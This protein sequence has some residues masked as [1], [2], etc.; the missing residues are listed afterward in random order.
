MNLHQQLLIFRTCLAVLVILRK[1]VQD[2]HNI[3]EKYS[4]NLKPI[5]ALINDEV[6]RLYQENEQTKV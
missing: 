5:I 4:Q 3:S 6:N 2:N 1:I